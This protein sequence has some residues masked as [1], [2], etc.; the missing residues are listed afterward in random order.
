[1]YEQLNEEAKIEA[2]VF[3]IRGKTPASYIATPDA[4][5]L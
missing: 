2:I 3:Q 1:M 4:N 5:I